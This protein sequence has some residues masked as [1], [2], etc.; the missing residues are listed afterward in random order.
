MIPVSDGVAWIKTHSFLCSALLS[1]LLP[2]HPSVKPSRRVE[3]GGGANLLGRHWVVHLHGIAGC[4]GITGCHGCSMSIGSLAA[5]AC[6]LPSG[7]GGGCRGSLGGGGGLGGGLRRC[8]VCRELLRSFWLESLL[9]FRYSTLHACRNA[10]SAL[11]KRKGDPVASVTQSLEKTGYPTSQ[12]QKQ[13]HRK[14]T[15]QKCSISR[16]IAPPP[17]S[18]L[19]RPARTDFPKPSRLLCEFLTGASGLLCRRCHAGGGRRGSLGRFL[20][21]GLLFLHPLGPPPRRPGRGLLRTHRRRC[22]H[23]TFL[24]SQVKNCV[25]YLLIIKL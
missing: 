21:W 18:P 1:S 7:L 10:W 8:H 4:H 13:L 9:G 17:L 24:F 20:L 11:Q 22:L 23:G 12:K 16:A 6:H 14:A 5:G 15:P 25:F 2:S 3:R 19:P